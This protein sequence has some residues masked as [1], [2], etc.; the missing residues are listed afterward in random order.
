MT[1]DYSKYEDILEDE[2]ATLEEELGGLGKMDVKTGD[3][4]ATPVVEETTS[5]ESDDADKADHFEDYEERTSTLNTLEARLRD[6]DLAL[7][8]IKEDKFGICEVC[9]EPIEEARLGTNPAARTC[10]EHRETNLS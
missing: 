4:E 7:Q 1:K 6:I 3:W 8:K 2:K 9:N 5:L 10:I